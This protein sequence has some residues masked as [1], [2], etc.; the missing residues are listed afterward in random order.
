MRRTRIKICG[1]RSQ[2]E[3]DAAVRAGADA[4]GFVFAARSPRRID[5][6]A[7]AQLVMSLPPFVRA[8]AVFKDQSPADVA[9]IAD[10]ACID[11]VQLHGALSLSQLSKI[12]EQLTVVRALRTPG[13]LL[14]W[15]ANPDVDLLM[16]DA[17]EGTGARADAAAESPIPPPS[18]DVSP[19]WAEL[20]SLRAAS[21]DLGIILAGGLTP[22]NVA[23]AIR[24]V[25]PFAV[26]VSSGVEDSPGLKNPAKIAAFCAAV[27]A[28]DAS[29]P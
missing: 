8:V 10:Q 16:I 24:T 29:L 15:S 4:V 12:A 6:D 26:D 27:R 7:A 25:R 23:D 1:L 2:E 21:D 18:S 20:A 22:S 9:R 17:S 14:A 19:A 3:V 11:M 28:A 5:P 13:E